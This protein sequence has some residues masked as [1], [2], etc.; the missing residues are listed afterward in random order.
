MA[1][2]STTSSTTSTASSSKGF[3]GLVSGMDTESLV[4]KLTLSSKNKIFK[5]QQK[6]QKLQ[7]K[8]E[9]YRD[10]TATLTAFKKSYFDT[11]S[12]TNF[13]NP[14]FFNAFKASTV[15]ESVKVT[16]TT[17][18]M[19]GNITIE[20]ISQLAEGQKLSSGSAI[21]KALIGSGNLLIDTEVG[22]KAL[23][24]S[25]KDKSISVNLDGKV[26]TI[27]FNQ[28][29][30]DAVTSGNGAGKTWAVS[31][32]D[33]MQVLLDQSFGKTSSGSSLIKANLSGNNLSLNST[34]GKIS[35][36]GDAAT[37]TKL[38]FQ[39]GQS[40]KINIASAL[41]DLSLA[42]PL[43][44]ENFD[45][46]INSVN[47]AF[48]KDDS[49][50]KV[51]TTINTSSA[52]V[53]L[54]YSSA[55]DQLTM[56]AKELGSGNNIN[57]VEAPTGNFIAALLNQATAGKNAELKVNGIEISRNSNTF[58]MD[59]TSFELL[60]TTAVNADPIAVTVTENSSTLLAP[61]VKFVSDYNT[62]IDKISSITKEKPLVEYQP[63]S[64]EQKGA[65]TE[66]QIKAW[67]IK[68]KTGLLSADSTL[69]G[70]AGKLKSML[71]EPSVIGG[72]ALYNIGITSAGW[73]Q[74]GK[75]QIDET[76]L[77]EALL[78]RGSEI[79][80]LFAS[81][82]G[83]ATKMDAVITSAVETKGAQGSRGTLIEIA[84]IALHTSDTKNNITRSM[85]LSAKTI[86]LLNTRLTSEETRYW[87]QFNAMESAISRLNTQSAML[88][89]QFSS[90]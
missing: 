70:I 11:L 86:A 53:I 19:P 73:Q 20:K 35:L 74:N 42:S 48:S 1:I 46:S 5:E 18:A 26:R 17:A 85:T 49:L 79:K 31:F 89:Q 38:G 54:S 36:S 34:S 41:K 30:S 63:L 29:F 21:S 67:E 13:K 80:V 25:L 22:I 76:I 90:K 7:W 77:K 27:S 44:G 71:Y 50:D 59:G 78:T 3:S 47:F 66:D 88:T 72:I 8:Q 75:L 40:N 33:E 57:I 12:A 43:V 68:A 58:L 24:T 16:A 64:D 69:V 55:T 52:G 62:L 65:M 15:S 84:G 82:S 56:A 83:L 6:S 60:K 81:T 14:A 10:V 51:I 61:I 23:A 39:A 45:F 2:R 37:L 87:S 9:A 32:M 4:S 28:A